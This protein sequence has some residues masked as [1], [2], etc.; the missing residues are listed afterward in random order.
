MALFCSTIWRD[1]IT[2]LMFRFLSHSYIFSC[3]ISLVCCLKYRYI[4]F[5]SNLVIDVLLFMVFLRCFL[6]LQSVF[7]RSILCIPLVIVSIYRRYLQS[8]SSLSSF[9]DIYSL[10][11]LS[12]VRSY[13]SSVVFL[14]SG[15]IILLIF[16]SALANGFHWSLEWQQVFSSL[17]DFS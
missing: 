6:W 17:L 12:N 9:I 3:E 11:C 16:T 5:I 8:C 1:S 14:F 4:C 2:L 7:L 10:C 13:A 15:I